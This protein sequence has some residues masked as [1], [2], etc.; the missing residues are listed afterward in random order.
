MPELEK[1]SA[2]ENICT[3]LTGTVL[4]LLVVY[5]SVWSIQMGFKSK[6]T[7]RF[8]GAVMFMAVLELPRFLALLITQDYTSRTAYAFH[9]LA[10]IFFF[11]AFSIVCRQWSG[12]LQLGSYF[13]VV[14]GYNSLIVSNVGFAIVD[15][16][17]VVLIA[18]SPSLMSFFE[19]SSFEAITFIEGVRNCIYSSFLCYYGIK[20]VRRFWHFSTME[21][22]A[23]IRGGA[24]VSS[25]AQFCP[26]LPFPSTDDQVFTKVVLRLSSVLV[27]TTFCFIFRVLMLILK[28]AMIHHG[29]NIY[30]HTNFKLFGFGWFLC[31]DFIPRALPTLAFIFL[32]RTKKTKGDEL[33]EGS[34]SSRPGMGSFQ[35]VPVA[36]SDDLQPYEERDIKGFGANNTSEVLLKGNAYDDVTEITFNRLHEVESQS[37]DASL[38]SDEEDEDPGEAAIDKIFSLLRV[39]SR[40]DDQL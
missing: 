16:I 28:M 32:M 12:L 2:L 31:S 35:F 15:L 22:Q 25:I 36:A 9:I 18:M 39:N 23:A 17:S 40:T 11:L 37:A 8:F 10:G 3:G 7:Q 20:L 19:S 5:F 24:M 30:Y 13:R 4:Y 6:S 29:D 1:P 27:L 26:S 21:R 34:M 14:Y 38:Y 33:A